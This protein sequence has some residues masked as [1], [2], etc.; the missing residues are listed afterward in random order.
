LV[1]ADLAAW[2]AP[3][4]SHA[5]VLCTGW[6]ERAVFIAAAETVA[7]GG[8]LGWEAFTVEARQA[9]PDLSSRWCLAAGEPASLLPTDF[10]VLDEH[11]LPERG[12]RQL[13]ARR[14]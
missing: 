8:L 14:H 3:P 12:R 4:R 7:S 11:D 6:W 13:L 2:P 5:L 1:H 9:R 10:T